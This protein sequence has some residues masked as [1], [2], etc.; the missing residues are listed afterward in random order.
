MKFAK[1]GGDESSAPVK[2]CE[3]PRQGAVLVSDHEDR[4]RRRGIGKG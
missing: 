2:S 3:D 1:S 4:A